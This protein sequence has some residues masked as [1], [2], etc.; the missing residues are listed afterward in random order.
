MATAPGD[1]YY[2]MVSVSVRWWWGREGGEGGGE[3]GRGG[4]RMGVRIV[5]CFGVY[6]VLLC[7]ST[8]SSDQTPSRTYK[9]IP[10]SAL[11]IWGQG[12]PWPGSALFFG[13]T[14]RALSF[15]SAMM[16]SDW[17]SFLLEVLSSR[18]H[19]KQL[20]CCDTRVPCAILIKDRQL[21]PRGHDI[22]RVQS[23]LR[24]Q[25]KSFLPSFS[26]ATENNSSPLNKSER[27]A[28][29]AHGFNQIQR[30][31]LECRRGFLRFKRRKLQQ[32]FDTN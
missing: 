25:F 10:H 15:D 6:D 8:L 27:V 26:L 4:R 14:V 23:P 30:L 20:P 29:R 28:C 19:E 13:G 31:K 16:A 3:G 17:I 5:S 32:L 22:A 18:F 21:C 24:E 11:V 9:K 2:T 1:E 12:L 7:L